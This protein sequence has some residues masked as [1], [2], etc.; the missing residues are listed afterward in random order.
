M[1]LVGLD[2]DEH[3][4][5]IDSL[6]AWSNDGPPRVHA[7]T[8]LQV[9]FYEEPVARHYLIAYTIHEDRQRFVVMWL[10]QQPGLR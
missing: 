3:E 6:V 10:R 2:P 4:A 5:I 7:R 8:L 9:T 1:D